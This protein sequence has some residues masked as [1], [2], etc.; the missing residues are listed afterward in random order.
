M[1][2]TDRHFRYLARIMSS[3]ARLYTEMVVCDALLHGDA[4]RFLKH[5]EI[6]APVAL[7][8]GGSNPFDLAR[9]AEIG[10]QAGFCE[11]N[12]NVGCPSARVKSGNFGAALMAEPNLVGECVSA[13]QSTVGVPVTVKTRIGIDQRDSYDHLTAFVQI[14]E[15]VGCKAIIVHARKAWL[16]GLSPRENR[17]I[18]PLRYGLVH[19]LKRDFP[20]MA[21]VINGGIDSL[22]NALTH[23]DSVDGVML[24]R[25]AYHTPYLLANVDRKI[26]RTPSAALDR[27]EI[28]QRYMDYAETEIDAGTYGRH[29]AKPLHYLFQGEPGAR[30]WR[31]HLSEHCGDADTLRLALRCVERAS[32]V[33][34]GQPAS[35]A[36][37]S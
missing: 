32:T 28:F 13:M 4:E 2:Y 10:E 16:Q 23:L 34:V 25:A 24:G 29:L 33:T 17:E 19:R 36:T 31:R 22:E 9:A 1:Q 6:E 27:F 21:V 3:H 26:F 15:S 5:S 18:P 20:T 7:Q 8:L 12:L 35:A 30:R 11:I 14:L 37:Q